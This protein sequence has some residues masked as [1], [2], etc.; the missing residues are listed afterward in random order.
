MTSSHLFAS[1]P[2]SPFVSITTTFQPS[3]SPN[4]SNVLIIVL[5]VT[6]ARYGVRTATTFS[7]PCATKPNED[8][9]NTAVINK[10]S[11]LFKKNTS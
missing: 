8:T 2:K 1:A 5:V 9:I 11:I 7:A 4:S 6:D 10:N 3:S